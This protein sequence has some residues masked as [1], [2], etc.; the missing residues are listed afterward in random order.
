MLPY[1]MLVSLANKGLE[2]SVYCR[3]CINDININSSM[4]VLILDSPVDLN[5]MIVRIVNLSRLI[6][7]QGLNVG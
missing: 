1:K 2:A 5:H 6:R 3:Q 7:R 4:R